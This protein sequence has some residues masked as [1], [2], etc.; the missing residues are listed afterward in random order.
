MMDNKFISAID[1][2]KKYGLSYQTVN[3]YTNLGL[4]EVL[5]NQGNKRLYDRRDVEERLGKITD[6]KRRGYPLRLIR[7]EILRRN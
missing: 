5:E 6:L 3:Y 7:D 1:I 2:V 4:L